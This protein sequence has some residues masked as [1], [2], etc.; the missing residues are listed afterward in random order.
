V[1]TELACVVLAHADPTHVRRLILALDPYPVFLHCDA[2]TDPD[3]YAAMSRDLPSRCALLPRISTPWARW[4]AV[5]AELSGYR[6]AIEQSSATHVAVLSGSDYPLHSTR[7]I[8]K[9]LAEH[10]GRS[11][12]RVHPLPFDNWGR[13]GG[14]ARLRFPHSAVG[15][16]IIRF[17]IPRRLPGDVIYAGASAPKILAREHAQRVLQLA[18]SRP[19]LL[20]FWRRS[21]C[22]DETFVPS[23]LNTPVMVPGFADHHLNQEVWYI[24]WNQV[25]QKS[26]PWLGVQDFPALRAA[27]EGGPK[28]VPRLFARKFS[29]T[30]DTE[31]LDLLDEMRSR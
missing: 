6:A 13:S 14:L 12:L 31:V 8:S 20:S 9:F 10:S 27:A 2:R 21:W 16:Q 22:A 28:A 11:I 17:P 3:V 26:P 5:E 24:G 1:T 19:D 15:R 30:H 7:S 18:G 4:P 23:V 25:R 29:T